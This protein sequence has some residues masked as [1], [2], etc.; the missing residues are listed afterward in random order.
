[1]RRGNW[2]IAGFALILCLT[3]SGLAKAQNAAAAESYAA[4]IEQICRRYAAAQRAQPVGVMYAECMYARGYLVPGYTPS[5][6][7]P[8]YQ[9]PLL[10]PATIGGG[11]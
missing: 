5:P 8:G 6:N 7:S 3:S 1:M 10:G 11:N 2:R 4:V 9:G